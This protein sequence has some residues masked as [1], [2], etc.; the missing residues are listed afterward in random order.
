MVWCVCQHGLGQLI[1]FACGVRSKMIQN[2]QTS[3]SS[4]N[5]REIMSGKGQGT[6]T[7]MNL[8]VVNGK[9]GQHRCVHGYGR[10]TREEED[11]MDCKEKT[12]NK[13]LGAWKACQDIFVFGKVGG[14]SAR[15]RPTHNNQFSTSSCSRACHRT[16]WNCKSH[17]QW[18]IFQLL[19]IV[20]Y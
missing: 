5:I 8:S 12:C 15:V 9:S 7:T 4:L 11:C 3:L 19:H 10:K 17:G 13:V 18:E 6:T 14:G 1:P 16:C 20:S 2:L